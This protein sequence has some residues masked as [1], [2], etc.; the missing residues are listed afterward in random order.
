M[1]KAS[2]FDMS[3]LYPKVVFD[4]IPDCPAATAAGYTAEARALAQTWYAP[5]EV[6][7]T[8]IAYTAWSG[9]ILNFDSNL[10]S[11]LVRRNKKTGDL[12]Y[13][14]NCGDYRLDTAD[15]FLGGSSTICRVRLFLLDDTLYLCNS[16]ISNLGPQ[17]YAVNANNGD[18]KW[19][20]AYAPPST[21]VAPPGQ[22]KDYITKKGDYSGLKGVSVAISDL[23]PTGGWFTEPSGKKVKLIFAGLS[24]FQNITN[25]DLLNGLFPSYDDKG[26]L[27][28]IQDLGDHPDVYWRSLT[29]APK[30]KVGDV[31]S[32][33]GPDY[34]DVF[35]PGQDKVVIF[36][37]SSKDNYFL[38]P[39]FITTGAS[40]I[41]SIPLISIVVFT[42]KSIINSSF[43]Q[44]IW[45]SIEEIYQGQD[46]STSYSLDKLIDG[47]KKEQAN[48]TDG[49]IIKHA[50]WTYATRSTFDIA[51]SNPGNE[52]IGYFKALSDGETVKFL[53]DAQGLN[54][55]GNSVWGYEPVI[56]FKNNMI[57][58]ESGQ[59]HNAIMDEAMY[60]SQPSL[61][62]SGVKMP[63]LDIVEM[64]ITKVGH[65]QI[66]DINIAK[67]AFTIVNSAQA[68]NVLPRSR[69]SR[70][71]YGDAVIGSYIVDMKTKNRLIKRGEMAYAVR[72]IP[73]DN[74]SFLDDS[75]EGIIY[76][77]QFQDA[78]ASSGAH[79]FDMNK[80]QYIS[81]ATKGG[82]AA[83][84][85]LTNIN[86]DVVFNHS[87]L[88]AK[89]VTV[90]Q[91]AYLGPNAALGGT[92]YQT[93]INK[94]ILF[95]TQA[96]TSWFSGSTT[97]NGILERQVSYDG[98]L[99]PI[100][101]SYV[102]AVNMLT[103]QPL[104]E[105]PLGS[106]SLG[107]IVIDDS[108]VYTQDCDGNLYVL[109]Q[110]TGSIKWK[111][112]GASV[113]MMGGI[114]SPLL[115]GD[116]SLVWANNYYAFGLGGHPG[117]SGVIFKPNPKLKISPSQEP[118]YY[119]NNNT[120]RSWD[121]SPKLSPNPAINP[122]IV[123]YV[124]HKWTKSGCK[125]VQ[126]VD[127]VNTTYQLAFG[128]YKYPTLLLTDKSGQLTD[129][130][131]TFINSKTY[132]FDYVS[133]DKVRVTAWLNVS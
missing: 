115:L 44:P 127:G 1:S 31:I 4:L 3:T 10:S 76:P 95:C 75:A 119:L 41:Q 89:G 93:A 17:L 120:F 101:N 106:R 116:G 94:S 36:S 59:T 29:C 50:I 131:L 68:L 33:K 16:S 130:S 60:Y 40:P 5:I 24:T 99:I 64:F 86:N 56:D 52:Q 8:D 7:D 72:T 54:T 27:V 108:N 28:C 103:G 100:N 96:N 81:V 118:Q 43:V 38:Q 78:D 85:N 132:R 79:R 88:A 124:V 87:N 104:W 133:F 97:T 90:D 77:I 46:R 82:I 47:W 57:H 73:F 80:S 98:K 45:S 114:S 58:W 13:A 65:L 126:T 39:H 62:F 112:N 49:Q 74:Y 35:R 14:R 51:K 105:T 2:S 6:G 128:K 110:L 42:N 20:I 61:S 113:G 71:N 63:M 121:S 55:Y 92:N 22:P 91:T 19:A 70:M 37:V 111:F 48:M 117:K 66:K 84:I 18:L 23:C 32:T 83:L 102:V 9:N 12:V 53:S 11:I 34:L 107:Q 30:I 69:S 109:D 21:Y 25:A 129:C 125:M 122:S 15:N 67:K 123:Y 26:Q